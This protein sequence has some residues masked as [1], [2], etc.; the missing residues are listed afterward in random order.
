[1]GDEMIPSAAP[2]GRALSGARP[3]QR[4][5]RATPSGNRAYVVLEVTTLHGETL[6]AE[7]S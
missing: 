1:M 5:A 7:G 4:S 3:G 2:L 6:T